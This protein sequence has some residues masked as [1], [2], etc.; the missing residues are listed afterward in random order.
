MPTITRRSPLSPKWIR[1]R[2]GRL[3]VDQYEAMVDSVAFTKHDNF[4][5]INGYLVT[6]V[7]KK[8]PTSSLA[9]F[10]G[11]NSSASFRGPTGA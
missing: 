8:R 5:L 4:V 3:T 6:K 11:T 1:K 2:L 9:N 10:S 7:T